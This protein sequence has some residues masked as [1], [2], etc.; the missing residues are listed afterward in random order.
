MDKIL[1][2]HQLIRESFRELE[3]RFELIYPESTCFSRA[4]MLHYLPQVVGLIP[5]FACK[6]DAEML[7]QAPHLKIIANFGAGYDNIDI[8][9]ATEM[10]IIVCNNPLA[11]SQPTAELAF[12]LMATL[13]RGIA[14][15]DREI[16]K[17]EGLPFGVMHNLGHGLYGKKLGIIG[18]GGIGKALTPFAMAA[19]MS[20]IYHNRAPLPP[21]DPLYSQLEYRTLEAL[22]QEADIVSIHVPLTPESYHLIN[23]ERLALMKPTAY[24]IN[25][26]RGPIIDEKALISALQNDQIAGAA[27]DV[28]EFEPQLSSQLTELHNVVLTPHLGTATVEARQAMIRHACQNILHYFDHRLT[29]LT[30]V[31]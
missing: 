27:L 28:F 23:R 16:R 1:V 7:Q 21:S 29:L 5:T 8:A 2:S 26:A 4:E 31:N 15:C 13:C 6:V 18:L 14:I 24:L 22:L 17:P 9:T 12:G 11:V 30:Q 25:T 19:N 10:G 3:S 20:I